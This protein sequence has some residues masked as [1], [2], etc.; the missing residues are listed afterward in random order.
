MVPVCSLLSR[1][2]DISYVATS[3]RF[4]DGDADASLAFQQIRQDS[5]LKFAICELENW[6]NP[7]AKSGG[8]A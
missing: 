2:T 5:L 6:R 3:I 8:Q 7:E 4:C 1:G